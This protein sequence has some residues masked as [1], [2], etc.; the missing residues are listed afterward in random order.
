MCRRQAERRR[1]RRVHPPSRAAR[2]GIAARRHECIALLEAGK[3][4]GGRAPTGGLAVCGQIRHGR[5]APPRPAPPLPSP[6]CQSAVAG[7]GILP[8]LWRPSW[9]Q[10]R[11]APASAPPAPS[12]RMR[13]AV[14]RPLRIRGRPCCPT[15]Q[16]G[17][18][19]GRWS[20][21][22]GAGSVSAMRLAKPVP[23]A[24]VSYSCPIQ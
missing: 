21:P 9:R 6:R 4:E 20:R 11:C 15:A 14:D 24:T 10:L 18:C 1:R 22:R 7:D 16:P 3:P 13:G 5:P 12:R 17:R 23:Y 8:R 19:Q 2:P